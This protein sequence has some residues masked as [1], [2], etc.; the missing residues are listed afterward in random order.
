[1]ACEI[2][3]IA[4]PSEAV[5][6]HARHPSS[7][8]TGPCAHD[9]LCGRARSKKPRLPASRPA[10]IWAVVCKLSCTLLKSGTSACRAGLVRAGPAKSSRAVSFS[11]ALDRAHSIWLP[12]FGRLTGQKAGQGPTRPPPYTLSNSTRGPPPP[13]LHCWDRI[14]QQSQ[15]NAH[16]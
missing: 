1:M 4:R 13:P 16:Q 11:S 14:C 7:T 2:L 10:P 9:G 3:A 8:T 5:R 6:Q 15:Q 12:S